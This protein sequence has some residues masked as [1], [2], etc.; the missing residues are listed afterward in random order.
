M[1]STGSSAQ[2]PGSRCRFHLG[3]GDA[4]VEMRD[5]EGTWDLQQPRPSLG[6][7]CLPGPTVVQLRHAG[8]QDQ[9]LP[10]LDLFRLLWRTTMSTTV[11]ATFQS[12]WA[13]L[14]FRPRPNGWDRTG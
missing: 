6:R 9:P 12:S 5:E 10:R 4:D 3:A 8:P 2:G 11:K 1:L 14:L 7:R 13:S